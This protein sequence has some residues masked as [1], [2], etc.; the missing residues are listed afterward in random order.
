MSYLRLC[1]T[2]SFRESNY[3]HFSQAQVLFLPFSFQRTECP[4]AWKQADQVAKISWQILVETNRNKHAWRVSLVWCY[5]SGWDF[6][7][8]KFWKQVCSTVSHLWEAVIYSFS[9]RCFYSHKNW[10]L[11]LNQQLDWLSLYR[12]YSEEPTD[13]GQSGHYL[14]VYKQQM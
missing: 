12:N 5:G 8:Q 4:S 7:N 9:Y 2:I 1:K 11:F 13:M 10:D 14:K 3:F 6:S